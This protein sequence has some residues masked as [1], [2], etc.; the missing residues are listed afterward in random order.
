[1][2]VEH[3]QTVAEQAAKMA[4]SFLRL[5]SF[6]D[7]QIFRKGEKDI[8]TNFDMESERLIKNHVLMHFPDHVIQAEESMIDLKTLPENVIWF[9][10]PVDGTRSSR[11]RGSRTRARI[12]FRATR[13]RPRASLHSRRPRKRSPGSLRN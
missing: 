2:N 9:I 11:R 1:M 10:D 5:M 4:G 3:L 6:K 12:A 8:V 7:L 13:S